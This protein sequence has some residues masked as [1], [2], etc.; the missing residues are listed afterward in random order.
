MFIALYFNYTIISSQLSFSKFFNI[1]SNDS[2]LLKKLS[3][4]IKIKLKLSLL[5]FLI[6]LLIISLQILEAIS[7]LF[8][9]PEFLRLYNDVQIIVIICLFDKQS[10]IPSAKK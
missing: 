3:N 1:L 10:Y 8:F 7:S 9:V 2:L 5:L 4:P 6:E